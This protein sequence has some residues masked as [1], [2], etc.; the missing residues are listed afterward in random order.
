MAINS[1]NTGAP[2]RLSPELIEEL[3]SNGEDVSDIE[4]PGESLSK[5]KSNK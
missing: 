4:I 1:G 5:S 3:R 2:I